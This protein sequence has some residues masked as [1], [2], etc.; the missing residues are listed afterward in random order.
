M[1]RGEGTP[2]LADNGRFPS[3][4]V[5]DYR[6]ESQDTVPIF[7]SLRGTD[8]EPKRLAVPKGP[9]GV[10]HAVSLGLEGGTAQDRLD[11]KLGEERDFV[12]SVVVAVAVVFDRAFRDNGWELVV[13]GTNGLVGIYF[14]VRDFVDESRKIVFHRGFRHLDLEFRIEKRRHGCSV[15]LEELEANAEQQDDT[16]LRTYVP[17]GLDPLRGYHRFMIEAE[18]SS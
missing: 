4:V 10:V 16:L 12:V 8:A 6:V 11:D 15:L 1:V 7:V 5:A 2:P 9:E 13:V 3:V 18:F 14:H 17:S